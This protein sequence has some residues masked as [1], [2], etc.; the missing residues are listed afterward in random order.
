MSMLVIKLDY[1]LNPAQPSKDLMSI[2]KITNQYG[3][4]L[5]ARCID[6]GILALSI[7]GLWSY[8][9]SGGGGGVTS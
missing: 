4:W 9:E 6:H 7:Q 5:I 2:Y 8:F 1:S 3:P